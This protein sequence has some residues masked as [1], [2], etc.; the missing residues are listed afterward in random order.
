MYVQRGVTARLLALLVCGAGCTAVPTTADWDDDPVCDANTPPEI[1]NLVL[2]SAFFPEQLA[3]GLC[4]SF[5]WIDP[6][7]D[8][9]GNVGSDPPN[10]V[11]GMYSSEFQG[12]VTISS[13]LSEDYVDPTAAGGSLQV[14]MNGEGLVVDPEDIAAWLPLNGEPL[15]DLSQCPDLNGNGIAEL[16]DCIGGY[17]MAFALRIRDRCDAPSEDLTGRYVLG[18]GRRVEAEGLTG[19]EEVQ[20]PA[21]Q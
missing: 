13:W 4:A 7:R 15:P 14:N 11:G 19:C 12:V 6:G 8:A 3:W 2:N 1:G 16:T 17:E 10:L 9:A 18:T 21:E 20:G 5:Q